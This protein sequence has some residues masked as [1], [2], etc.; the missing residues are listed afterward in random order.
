MLQYDSTL[1]MPDWSMLGERITS[2][3]EVFLKDIAIDES[4]KG[5]LIGVE[6]D[7]EPTVRLFF[8]YP[9]RDLVVL[10]VASRDYLDE[11]FFGLERNRIKILGEV[12]GFLSVLV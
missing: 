9:E 2:G 6:I 8:G 3:D 12:V 11:L 5:I 7:G 10:H 1:I 4:G